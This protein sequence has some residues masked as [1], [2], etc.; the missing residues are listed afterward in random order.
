MAVANAGKP[1]DPNSI[2]SKT[3]RAMGPRFK[4][5]F[6]AAKSAPDTGGF[7]GTTLPVGKYSVTLD[8]A[9][10]AMPNG[11]LKI[12]ISFLDDAGES[13]EK[14]L[15][16][17]TD[18]KMLYTAKDL[19]RL[20]PNI[21]PETFMSN[22]DRLVG[23]LAALTASKPRVRITI[24]ADKKG[25]INPKTGEVYTNVWIDKLLNPSTTGAINGAAT[26]SAPTVVVEGPDETPEPEVPAAPI[27]RG[28]PPKN[29]PPVVVAPAPD[30]N[31]D[32]TPEDPDAPSNPEEVSVQT[33]VGDKVEF[34][35]SDGGLIRGT[36]VKD[37]GDNTFNVRTVAGKLFGP[38]HDD[39][40]IILDNP[41]F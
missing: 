13:A 32:E 18:E 40:L 41:P 4:Q 28:R 39:K 15:E 2:F 29:A 11:E 37:N 22:P 16:T 26:I 30:P 33:K 12:I 21:E 23:I 36:V 35:K 25:T 10:L 27:R 34:A 8:S 24:S 6:T 9:K 38:V 17:S 19:V 14:W 5:A 3:L 7:L 31:E 1:T 20:D